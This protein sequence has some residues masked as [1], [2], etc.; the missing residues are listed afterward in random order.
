[1]FLGQV[2]HH[3]CVHK[4]LETVAVRP[5]SPHAARGTGQQVGDRAFYAVGGLIGL[6]PLIDLLRIHMFMD[7][8]RNV[9]RL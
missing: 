4:A 9:R 5:G 7:S 8:L 2:E 3:K 1:M 6:P